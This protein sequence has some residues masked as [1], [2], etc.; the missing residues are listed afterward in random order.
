MSTVKSRS[1]TPRT[2]N[3]RAEIVAAVQLDCDT[4]VLLPRTLSHSG[5]YD[6]FQ[7]KLIEDHQTGTARFDELLLPE[8]CKQSADG[9][10]G[11]ADHLSYFFMR[12]HQMQV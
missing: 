2:D 11:R 4:F 12:Q 3:H 8:I 1:P 5:L 9:L 6:P 7:C 10:A